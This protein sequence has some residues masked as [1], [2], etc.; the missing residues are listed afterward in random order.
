MDLSAAIR[1]KIHELR[2]AKTTRFNALA[3]GLEREIKVLTKR[4]AEVFV[5]LEDAIEG[6]GVEVVVAKEEAEDTDGGI[7]VEYEESEDVGKG[8]HTEEGDLFVE[9]VHEDQD[10]CY[11]RPREQVSLYAGI[12][13]PTPTPSLHKPPAP[14]KPDDAIVPDPSLLTS[15]RTQ[16]TETQALLKEKHRSLA[17]LRQKHASAMKRLDKLQADLERVSRQWESEEQLRIQNESVKKRKREDEG[18]ASRGG[19]KRLATKGVECA[20]MFGVG[21]VTAVGVDKL[22]QM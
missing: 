2:S 6:D 3:E 8:T 5:K 18:E 12:R 7:Q 20:V 9:E 16:A 4:N 17:H 15:L 21:V 11:H 13:P 22:R 10:E 1:N 19:W 14:T